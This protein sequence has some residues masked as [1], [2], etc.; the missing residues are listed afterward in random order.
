ML[1]ANTGDDIKA[2]RH[3]RLPTRFVFCD[4][5]TTRARHM[6][7]RLMEP[8]SLHPRQEYSRCNAGVYPCGIECKVCPVMMYEHMLC[9]ADRHD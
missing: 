8:A 7:P 1:L 4:L 5:S 3:S 9:D 2:R 6:L